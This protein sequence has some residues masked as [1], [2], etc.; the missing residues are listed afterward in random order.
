MLEIHSVWLCKAFTLQAAVRVGARRWPY[1]PRSLQTLSS[2]SWDNTLRD[3][4]PIVEHIR[5]P[6][7]YSLL[8]QAIIF[9]FSTSLKLAQ[10]KVQPFQLF[11]DKLAGKYVHVSFF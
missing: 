9:A 7:T 2:L 4:Q 8:L 3:D 1:F 11:E 10:H 5:S 6:F